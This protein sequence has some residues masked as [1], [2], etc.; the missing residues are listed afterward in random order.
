MATSVTPP[1]PGALLESFTPIDLPELTSLISS[2]KSSMCLLNPIPTKLLTYK[3]L[4]GLAP[5]YLKELPTYCPPRPLCFQS[6]GLLIPRLSKSTIGG[7]ALCSSG[8]QT[9]RAVL[10]RRA[11][12]NPRYNT[13]CVL[14][15]S[16]AN[17]A[18]M[19]YPALLNSHAPCQL[20][21]TLYSH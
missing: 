15:L 6:A 8:L 17:C 4:N 14:W 20:S 16:P 10:C 9:G 2:S 7:R 18:L 1:Q 13:R 19:L 5:N 3:A 21:S 11:F 12:T